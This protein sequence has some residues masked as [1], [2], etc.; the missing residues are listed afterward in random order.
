MGLDWLR[1]LRS[2]HKMARLLLVGLVALCVASTKAAVIPVEELVDGLQNFLTAP[3]E[4]GLRLKRSTG[5]WDKEFDL[6]SMGVLFQLKYTNPANPFEGGRAHVKVPGARFVRNAPFG[7]MEMDIEFNGGSAIDGLF[8]MKVDYKF[9]QKFMFLADRPQEGSFVLYRKMEGGMW[10]TRVTIDNNN[11]MP[12]P[13]LDIAVESDRKTKL[14]VLFNFEE[15]N[16]WELKIDRVPGQKMTIEATIN[17]QKWTGV[18]NLNQGDM[19]LNL[20]MD[21]EFTGKH[22]SV[23]FDLNPAGMWGLHVTGDVEGPVDAKWTMQ[24]DFTMGEISIKYKN[25]NYAFMQLKGNAEKRGMF[26]IMFDY[27][28][29][30]NINDAEQHQGKAK[31]KFDARAPAKKFEISSAPKTGTPFEYTFDFDLSSGFKYDSDLKVN[32]VTVEKVVGE[33]KW[34]N[35]AGKFELESTEDYSQTKENPF[36]DLAKWMCGGHEFTAGVQTRKIFFDKVNKARFFNKMSFEEKTVFDGKTWYHIKYDNTAPRT[37]FLFTFLPY[38]MDRAWTYEGGREHTANGGFAMTHKITHG[39]NVIQEGEMVFDIKTNDGAKF[40]MEHLHKMTMTEESPFYGMVF[41][42]TGRYGKNVERKMTFVFDKIN[43]SFLFVPKMSMNTIDLAW[44]KMTTDAS[45]L[46]FG[47][48]IT[49]NRKVVTKFGW[50]W[51]GVNKVYLDVVGNN[52]W[53]GDYKMS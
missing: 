52:P 29:K 50:E 14:H 33:Y 38:N 19:K 7:D 4:S 3:E 42:Y 23:D 49:P 13:F 47:V 36:Y 24:K 2:Q 48:T 17:G 1:L 45:D 46:E 5:D 40:E 12:K 26:P 8:D 20:K 10:K 44:P 6:S 34:T 41:W 35:D 25:Q 43:K 32:S 28:V 39:E 9:I 11:R 21:S 30:Y 51:A 27:V 53:I 15:D 16:K 18:G 22:F 31:L 37:A